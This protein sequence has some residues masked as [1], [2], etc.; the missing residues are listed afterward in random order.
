MIGQ[1]ETFI[2]PTELED[3]TIQGMTFF[4]FCCIPE[5]YTDSFLKQLS[6]AL[7]ICKWEDS[8]TF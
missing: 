8:I 5:K 4:P 1:E 2:L 7:H 6:T 3:E